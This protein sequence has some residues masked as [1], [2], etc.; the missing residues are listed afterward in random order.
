MS[1]LAFSPAADRDFDDILDYLQQRNPAAAVR[2]VSRLSKTCERVA[3]HP[4]AGPPCEQLGAGLRHVLERPYVIFYRITAEG[5][6]VE[7]IL[8]GSRDAAALLRHNPSREEPSR[9]EE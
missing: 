6:R 4:Y 5:I 8:H 7:R 3:R 9:E 2:V 1:E